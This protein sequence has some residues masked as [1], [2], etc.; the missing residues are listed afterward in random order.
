MVTKESQIGTHGALPI[1]VDGLDHESVKVHY[2]TGVALKQI[3]YGNIKIYKH[4]QI[5]FINHFFIYINKKL[6]FN[7]SG[8]KFS[9]PPLK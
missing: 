5:V 1:F 7:K 8:G 4:I 9:K 6:I 3:F 2:K